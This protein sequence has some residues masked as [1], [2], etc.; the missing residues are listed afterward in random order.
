MSLP[1]TY[2]RIDLNAIGQNVQA[3]KRCV[4]PR[5]VL[6]AVVKAN[7][8]GHGIVETAR[9]ALANG[10]ERLAVA[11]VSEGVQL[12]RA[13]VRAPILVLG[14]HTSA[15]AEAVVQYDLIATVNSLEMAHS[16]AEQARRRDKRVMV[17]I[18][19]DTGMGRFGLL[20]REALPFWRAMAA[21]PRFDVEGLWTHFAT[22]DERDKGYARRQLRIFLDVARAIEQAGFTIAIRHAANSAALLDL[23]ESHLDMVRPGIAIYGLRPSNEVEPSVPLRPALSLISHVGR[24][25]M[26]PA[27]SS[28]SYGRTFITERAMRVALVPVGYGDGYP[29][30]LSNRGEA[31]VRGRR[32]RILGRVCMDNLVLDVDHIPDVREGDEV[33]LIG[34]QGGAKITAEEVAGWA[35]TINYEVTTALL[36]RSPRIYV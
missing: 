12:R 11:R 24:V 34:R 3:L 20:P 21:M 17:H 10:A 8:Y 18:K 19:V 1:T 13:G 31:L 9:A 23:P 26:L 36:P 29:R 4:G 2:V 35:E 32:A 25:R 28:V 33:V 27:G 6:M 16:L 7:A 30:I 15:E 5:V 22:A 14:Y